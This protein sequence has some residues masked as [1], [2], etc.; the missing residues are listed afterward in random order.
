MNTGTI[1][2]IIAAFAIITAVIM[3]RRKNE[4]VS[5]APADYD[6]IKQKLAVKISEVEAKTAEISE[7]NEKINKLTDNN[8]ISIKEIAGLRAELNMSEKK[9]ENQKTEFEA[10]QERTK[11]DFENIAYKIMEKNTDTFNKNSKEKLDEILKPFN[12]KLGEFKKKVEETSEKGNENRTALETLIKSLQDQTNKISEEANNLALALKGDN[13]VQGD[14][15]ELQLE[16]LLEKLGFEE[17]VHYIKQANFKDEHNSNT[18]PDFVMNLPEN[19]HCI[20]DCKVSFTAYERF[21]KSEDESEKERALKEHILSINRHIKELS[22]KKYEK[23]N[24]INSPDFVFMFVPIEAALMLAI[25]NDPSL[26]EDAAKKNVMLVS[27]STLLFALRTVAYIWKVDNQNKN[28]QEIA[29]IGGELYDKFVGFTDNMIRV[30][31][32]MDSAKSTY[33]N[34]MKQLTKKNMDGSENAGT[35]VGKI[36]YMKELGAGAAKQISPILLEKIE[37]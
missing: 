19:R 14:W 6:D 26:A 17:N 22:D 7:L 4:F 21:F 2:T 35:I 18:R 8:I 13:K 12:E 20:I 1:I 36:E 32:Q 25:Q 30:G 23:L 31:N 9:L 27:T 24:G 28:V 3:T 15:G 37:V 33:D 10:M 29:K 16:V 5:S 11:K 34:A